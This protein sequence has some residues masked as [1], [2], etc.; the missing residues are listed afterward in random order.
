MSGCTQNLLV[1]TMLSAQIPLYLSVNTARRRAVMQEVD[2]STRLEA[3]LEALYDLVIS[4]AKQNNPFK[5][6]MQIS[7]VCLRIEDMYR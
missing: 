5:S 7:M 3:E 1:E 2:S 4:I 6:V